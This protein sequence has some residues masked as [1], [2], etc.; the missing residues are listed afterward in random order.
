[1]EKFISSEIGHYDVI[2]MDITMPVMDGMEATRKIRELN[3]P[4]AATVPVIAMTAD[5]FEESAREA[6]KSGMDEYL[7][8]PIDP[9]KLLAALL[10]QTGRH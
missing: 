4:D 1:V 5:A 6:L 9:D 7:T 3:R 10:R 2:L 8:K